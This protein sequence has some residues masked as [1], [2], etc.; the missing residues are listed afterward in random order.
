MRPTPADPSDRD[1]RVAFEAAILRDDPLEL[2]RLV[3]AAALESEDR[4]WAEVCCAQLA[5]HHNAVVR[6]NAILAF[7]HLARRFG[8]LDR[9]RVKRLV[10]IALHANHEY[11]RR[12]AES[13]A[14]DLE[15]FL[16]WRLERPP[17]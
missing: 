12:Q 5:K 1:L 9:N 14:D 13:A 2:E 4:V 17:A 11:V 16:S 3:L 6:G 8:V 15:T 10:E 7:G